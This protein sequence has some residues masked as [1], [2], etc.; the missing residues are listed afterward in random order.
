MGFGRDSVLHVPVDSLRRPHDS[1]SRRSAFP[2]LPYSGPLSVGPPLPRGGG[3]CLKPV[4]SLSSFSRAAATTDGGFSPVS[5]E[6]TAW[7]YALVTSSYF[8]PATMEGRAT[9]SLLCCLTLASWGYSSKTA[10]SSYSSSSLGISECSLARMSRMSLRRRNRISSSASWG[11]AEV[12]ETA[13]PFPPSVLA[14]PALPPGTLVMPY[15][16]AFRGGGCVAIR[17]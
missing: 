6:C 1:T 12:R 2:S 9:T 10:G 8:W 17:L 13:K 7:M 5:T 11:C 15:W 4:I 14:R 3:P 16:V